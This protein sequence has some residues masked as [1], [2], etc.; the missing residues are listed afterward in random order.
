MSESNLRVAS[1]APPKS[2][3]DACPCGSGKRYKACHGAVE[4]ASVPSATDPLPS[5]MSAALQAQ[6]TG[7]LIEAERLYRQALT[8]EPNQTDCLHMLGVVRLQRLDLIEAKNVDCPSWGTR[9]LGDPKFSSQLWPRV[10][11]VFE[12][13]R[14]SEPGLANGAGAARA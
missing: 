4:V 8:I 1:V 11:I 3:N 14:T 6:T 7:D 5:I 10:V 9:R 13:T 12:R 2:R